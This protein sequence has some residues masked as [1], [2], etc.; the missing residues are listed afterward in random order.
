MTIKVGLI[1]CGDIT[2]VHVPGYLAIPDE[3]RVTAVCDVVEASARA[4]A[5]TLGG[6]RVYGDYHALIAE[7]DVDAVD[8]CLPHHLHEDAIVAAAAAGKHILCEKPLCLNR[9]QAEAI[10][11]AVAAS[12]VTLMCAH[13]QLYYPAV[14]RARQMLNDGLMGRLYEIRAVEGF[15][16]S[17]EDAKQLEGWRGKKETMGGG[18]L[19][20]TGYHP[21]YTLLHLADSKPVEVCAMLSRHA[22]HAMDGEDSAHVMVRFADGAI[23]E[24]V[25]SWA[26]DLRRGTWRFQIIGERGQ[27]YGRP[28]ELHYRINDFEPASL[29]LPEVNTF[30]AEIADFVSCLRDGRSPLQSEAHG[31][32]V[33]KVI[34]AAYRSQDEKRVI[35]L[36]G[37]GW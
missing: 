24:V 5:A 35:E 28:S 7:A 15:R 20:D 31:I 30:T 37:D 16:F 19:I 36:D 4:V 9:Q 27:L 1:G 21:M 8:I 14:R 25:S 12:G 17:Q 11:S 26:Y 32:D 6:A 23:G 29:K 18:E 34:L 10:A 33:V 2:S 13:N 3:V 22:M